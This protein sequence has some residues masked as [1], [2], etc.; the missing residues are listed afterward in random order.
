LV[1]NRAASSEP[2][3]EPDTLGGPDRTPGPP[4]I[5]G[6][7]EQ[8]QVLTEQPKTDSVPELLDRIDSDLNILTQRNDLTPGI[9]KDE[10][11]FYDDRGITV[12]QSVLTLD[13][14][15]KLGRPATAG[16]ISSDSTTIKVDINNKG[17]LIQVFITEKLTF[18]AAEHLLIRKLQI[19]S[20]SSTASVRVFLT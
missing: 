18:S 6:T 9:L 4:P 5:G 7:G 11:Y 10:S 13:V 16:F 2:E 17:Q 3:P 8:R 19:S 1:L 20:A 15:A 14:E 12:A